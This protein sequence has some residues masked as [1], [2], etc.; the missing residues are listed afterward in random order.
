MNNP[1]SV[2]LLL[3]WEKINSSIEPDLHCNPQFS[4]IIDIQLLWESTFVCK[5]FIFCVLINNR[6]NSEPHTSNIIYCICIC[7]GIIQSQELQSYLCCFL[8]L[9]VS[10]SLDLV[11]T[12]SITI[13]LWITSLHKKNFLK[14]CYVFTMAP[15]FLQ[16]MIYCKELHIKAPHAEFK[17]QP[18]YLNKSSH[19]VDTA[20]GPIL[21]SNKWDLKHTQ[22][23]GKSWI[24]Q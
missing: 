16:P 23:N 11:K 10:K 5:Q 6:P 18:G 3:N 21:V 17:N 13:T 1:K 8:S 4:S 20:F 7:L 15:R 22:T 24:S 19:Q 14:S 2:K 12:D 9:N